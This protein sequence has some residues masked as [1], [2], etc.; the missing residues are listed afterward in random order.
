MTRLL[1][2]LTVLAAVAPSARAQTPC[3][4]ACAAFVAPADLARFNQSTTITT[5]V[6]VDDA[7]ADVNRR[8]D[9]N[10]RVA[11]CV[12]GELRGVAEA[13]VAGGQ[14]RYFLSVA[15]APNERDEA[16]TLV[17]CSAQ[18][19]DVVAPLRPA[20]NLDNSPTFEA[21]TSY[22]TPQIP[23]RVQVRAEDLPVELVAFTAVA[24]GQGAAVLRWR[25]ASEIDNAGFYVERQSSGGW[26]EGAFVLGNGTTL[27][28]QSYRHRVTGLAP[29]THR[30]RL[31]Q[32]DLD[33]AFEY[34]PVVEVSVSTNAPA[35]LW[36]PS[37]LRGGAGADVRFA[38][39]R[40]GVVRVAVY[41]LLGR[42]VAEL[43]AGAV[44]AGESRSVRWSAEGQA[45]G[46]YL[47]VLESQGA[48]TTRTL[49]LVR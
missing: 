16:I 9:P 39:A 14:A 32:V 18:D 3:P 35:M 42:S 23:Y 6:Y 34:S 27:E 7:R 48:R 12:G 44:E 11:G 8:D 19:G 45:S 17:Y 29:G 49:T 22:G 15:G 43:Y 41:S 20:S 31:R 38:V 40:A 26:I 5:S 1:S 13:Q 33:G 21:S 36:A 10:A 46:L 37:I 25:T 4:T 30:F 2:L 28:T 47:L 24:D